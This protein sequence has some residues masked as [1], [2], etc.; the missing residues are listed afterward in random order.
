RLP[1]ALDLL[2]EAMPQESRTADML[3]EY[4]LAKP[5]RRTMDIVPIVRELYP[6]YDRAAN[7][8]PSS[9]SLDRIDAIYEIA[10]IILAACDP[11]FNNIAVTGHI[12]EADTVCGDECNRP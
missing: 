3:I 9:H 8:L 11:A 5:I 4:G 2:T 10:R 6:A 7:P 12:P 1:M